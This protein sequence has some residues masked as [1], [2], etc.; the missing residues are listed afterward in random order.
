MRILVLS[1]D[2][3]PAPPHP[4]HLKEQSHENSSPGY[5]TQVQVQL[6]QILNILKEQSHEN[7]SPS[8]DP[9]I[10]Q[11]NHQSREFF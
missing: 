6:H 2:V 3:G 5:R 10:A 11:P 4:Q 1:H 9:G 8:H 7:S